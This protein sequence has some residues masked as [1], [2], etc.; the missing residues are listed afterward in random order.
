MPCTI[1]S[2]LFSLA[3][4]D[5]SPF[6]TMSLKLASLDAHAPDG[7]EAPLVRKGDWMGATAPRGGICISSL[8][9]LQRG[10]VHVPR[11]LDR[12][13]VRLEGASGHDL[14]GHLDGEV[15]DGP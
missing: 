8:P 2:A 5:W 10:L 4:T 11:G 14:A 15:A 3:D 1:E 7:D 9:D 13:L 12:A 6:A